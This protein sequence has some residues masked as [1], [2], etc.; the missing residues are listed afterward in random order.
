MDDAVFVTVAGQHA[1]T[2]SLIYYI[3]LKSA[4]SHCSNHCEKPIYPLLLGTTDTV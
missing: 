1:N 2:S 4:W 3:C